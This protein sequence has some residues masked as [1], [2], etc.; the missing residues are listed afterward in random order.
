[1]LPPLSVAPKEMERWHGK[2]TRLQGGGEE[3]AKMSHNTRLNIHN[4][5]RVC[6]LPFFSLHLVSSLLFSFH[7][8]ASPLFSSLR[9]FSLLR[10][11]PLFSSYLRRLGAVPK[12]GGATCD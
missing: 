5:Q 8:L 2:M 7:L 10:C 4:T 6:L 9:F 3:S 1:M 11:S 12:S